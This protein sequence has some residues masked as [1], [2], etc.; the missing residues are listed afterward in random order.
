[1][2]KKIFYFSLSLF[3]LALI[4]LGAYNFA[5]KNNINSPFAEKPALESGQK[6]IIAVAG[7]E[8]IANVINEELLGAVASADGFL[9]Y[10][11]LDDQALK[12]STLE[13]K[14]KTI[15]ISNLPGTATRVLFTKDQ[16]QALLLLKQPGGGTLWHLANLQTKSLTPLKAEMGR[17]AWDNLGG[18]ISYQYTDPVT[19]SR[20]LNIANPDGSEWKKLADLGVDDS[21]LASVPQS[22]LVSF[23]NRP[24]ASSL[25]PLETV[26]IAGEKRTFFSGVF[27]GDYSW[28]PDGDRLLISGSD[29]PNGEGFSLRVMQNGGEARSLSLPTIITKTVWSKNDRVVYYALPGGLPENT[30]LPDDYFSKPLSTKDTFWKVDVTTG[31]K[32]RL[33]ELKAGTRSFDSS[34][35]FLSEEEE[36]LFF[37]DRTDKRLYRIEL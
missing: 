14:S 24:T 11:S 10:Y 34:E 27:G 33:I 15:L 21:F 9:Y 1:M 37:I 28:S 16:D 32:S 2:A 3:I 12:R 19:G 22:S 13:G 23:W 8:K 31:K 4:F 18:K 29:S 7:E 6:E 17:L 20:S 36:F 26:S 5:F 25:A 30:L 35:L